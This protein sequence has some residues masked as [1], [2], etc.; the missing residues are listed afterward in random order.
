MS[1][2]LEEVIIVCAGIMLCIAISMHYD[3]KALEAENE[4]L[5]T[6]FELEKDRVVTILKENQ[7]LKDQLELIQTTKNEQC[8]LLP[9]PVKVGE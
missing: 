1:R 2:F 9:E 5:K 3:N 4:N 8:D 7:R 6:E